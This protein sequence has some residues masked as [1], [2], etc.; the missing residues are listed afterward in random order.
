MNKTDKRD[1]STSFRTRLVQAAAMNGMNQSAL[2]RAV[3]VDRSTISQL[4]AGKN[5]R[6]PNAQVVAECARALGVS[7]DWLLGLTERPERPGD[8]INSYMAVTDAVRSSADEQLNKWH[9]EAAGYKIRHVPATLP[10]I[11]KT[12][13]MLTWEYGRQLARTAPQAIRAVD[14]NLDWFTTQNSD[15]EIAFPLHE[16]ES[17]ARA[18][19]YYRGLSPDIRLAQLDYFLSLYEEHFPSLRLFLFDAR[20]VYSAPISVFG[21]LLAVVYLG[22]HYIAFRESSRIK[23]FTAQFDSL[24]REAVVDARDIP[25]KLRA[26]RAEISGRSRI[27]QL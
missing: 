8:V 19:G 21:P 6:L 16:L 18:E 5:A 7:A 1:R 24:V 12:A 11:L 27:S 2:S 26:L 9:H 17:F 15:Y 10:D 3:G 20:Q 23:T 4:M 22:Q 25:D 13:D 14:D